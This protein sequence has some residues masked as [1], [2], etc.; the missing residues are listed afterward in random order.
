MPKPSLYYARAN[1]SIHRFSA[2]NVSRTV[3]DANRLHPEESTN[4]DPE[5]LVERTYARTAMPTICK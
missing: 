5:E 4:Y 3:G 2:Q 1:N